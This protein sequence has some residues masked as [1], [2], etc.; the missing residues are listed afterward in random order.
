M[1]ETGTL[2]KRQLKRRARTDQLLETAIDMIGQGGLDAFSMH[3]LAAAM[4]LTVGALYRYFPSKGSLIAT[5]EKRVI[6]ETHVAI[7]SALARVDDAI[8][9]D[10]DLNLMAQIIATAYAYRGRLH[11]APE[12][13]RLIGGLMSNPTPLLDPADAK[14]VIQQMLEVLSTVSDTVDAAVVAGLLAPGPATHRAVLLWAALRG[15]AESRKLS[16]HNPDVFDETA[17]FAL[18]LR[19]L[20]SGWGADQTLFE[21]AHT[22]VLNELE[23]TT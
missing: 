14:Q 2:T 8:K 1:S 11:D 13:M 15:V 5:L 3:K 21:R 19:A 16:H 12:Q 17:L 7:Q 22:F 6:S 9:D 10:V 4:Q 18:A 23:I 20:L